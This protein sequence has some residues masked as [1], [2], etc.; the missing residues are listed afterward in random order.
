MLKMDSKTIR[1]LARMGA[2]GTLGQA[3]YDYA[4]EGNDFFAVSAD[5]A[6]A[7]G[8][9]R[10]IKEYPDHFVDVGIAEQNLIGVSAGLAEMG[11]PVIA[12]SWAMFTSV[13]AA[14]QVRNF[15][16]YMQAN[17]KLIGMDSGL[18]QS[19][20]G[21]SHGNPPDIA[22]MRSIPG[23]VIM[24]PC[25][26]V[27]VYKSLEAALKYDGPVYIRLTGGNLQPIIHRDQAI[28][29]SI[30]KSITLKEGKDVAIAACGNIVKNVM[31]AA[32]VL[33]DQGVSAKVIDMHTVNPLDTEILE[34]IAK[35]NLLV[36]V[37]EH[38][39]HG[40]MGAAIAEYYADKKVRPRHVLAGIDNCY[41]L[42]GRVSYTEETYGLS[43]R[44]IAERVMAELQK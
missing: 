37:E 43:V 24:S 26:G 5:L 17:I 13:R 14:D 29:F 15:M 38:L 33:E 31:D 40:G 10:I 42:P 12:T 32:A 21:Y 3:V 19:R 4:R 1:F 23:I 8:F 16:G 18:I 27:E 44:Q 30:G 39:I 22:V 2:R 25:D 7:S 34:E 20:F 41:P 35:M 9:D 36:S 11:T 28:P 6:H